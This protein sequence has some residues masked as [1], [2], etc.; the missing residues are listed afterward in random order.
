MKNVFCFVAL[1]FLVF[2]CKKDN[3][4]SKPE[5]VKLFTNSIGMKLVYIPPGEFVMGSRDSTEEV[6]RKKIGIEP[7]FLIAT[8]FYTHEYPQHRVKITKGFY[9][10]TTEV[11]QSHYEQITRRKP[12]HFNEPEKPIDTE[13]SKVYG[14]LA[15]H[16]PSVRGLIH[17]VEKVG[18]YDAVEFCKRLSEREGKKYRL[19]TEAEWEYACRA[20]TTTPFYTGETIST[21]QANYNGDFVYGNG[22]KGSYR[23]Q[24]TPVGS[25]SPNDFGL[26]DMHGNVWEW[27]QDLYVHDYY[28]SSPTSNPQGPSSIRFP[29]LRDVFTYHVIRGGAWD[30]LP[31]NCRSAK[32]YLAVDRSDYNIGFRVVQELN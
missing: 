15:D 5:P 10:S 3:P 28:A 31:W 14:G 17:P 27:C 8:D 29:E 25:F 9:M 21:N 6:A 1:I 26:Y 16:K 4:E 12:S 11:T 30:S 32:R 13:D 24:T 2:G 7:E 20:G 18:W 23:E 22:T 19:P